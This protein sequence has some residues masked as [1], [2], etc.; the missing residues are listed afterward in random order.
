MPHLLFV[1]TRARDAVCGTPDGGGDA[2]GDGSRLAPRRFAPILPGALSTSSERPPA[3]PPAPVPAEAAQESRAP[4][5]P[6][7]LRRQGGGAR[8][9]VSKRVLVY[10]GQDELD[11]WALNMSRGGLRIIIEDVLVAGEEIRI[12]IGDEDDDDFMVRSA[13]IAWAREEPD[14]T[15]AGVEFSDDGGSAPPD[16]PDSSPAGAGG[17]P[18]IVE[19]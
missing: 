11:G 19:S 5:A 13:R 12:S 8:V 17:L 9:N 15:I 7:S 4:A 2:C 14:G 1:P 10:R 16:E 3:V 18:P 6:R